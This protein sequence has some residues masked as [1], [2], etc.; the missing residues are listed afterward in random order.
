MAFTLISFTP[1]LP[2]L[3]KRPEGPHTTVKLGVGTPHVDDTSKVKENADNAKKM[4]FGG[5][6]PNIA[7]FTSNGGRIG[8][9]HSNKIINDANTAIDLDVMHWDKKGGM[10]PSA[11]ITVSAGGPDAICI[12]HVTV[13]D[14]TGSEGVGDYRFVPG[15]VAKECNNVGKDY[16]WFPS[17]AEM[18]ISKD[19]QDY[20]TH[21]AW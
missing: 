11:Y 15:E 6:A 16:P 21:P 12:S 8:T 17:D 20:I 2:G 3:F 7:L 13:L 18:R 9:Y 10:G 14:P 19:G 1:F 5:D 4:S